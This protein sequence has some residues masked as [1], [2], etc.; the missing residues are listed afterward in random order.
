MSKLIRLSF[1]VDGDSN[2]Q[3]IIV[4]PIADNESKKIV[5]KCDCDAEKAIDPLYEKIAN[6]SSEQLMDFVFT[7]S[8]TPTDFIVSDDETEDEIYSDD[9]FNIVPSRLNVDLL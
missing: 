8:D 7:V 2:F 4:L 1:N 6:E 3:R 5:S 9:E